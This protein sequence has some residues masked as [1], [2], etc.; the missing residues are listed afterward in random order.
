MAMHQAPEIPMQ[1]ESRGY[2]TE[3]HMYREPVRELDR[4]TLLFVR[5]L[6]EQGLLEHPVAGPPSGP[7]AGFLD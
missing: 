6:V 3:L 5:W 7:M 1:P 2:D 4:A